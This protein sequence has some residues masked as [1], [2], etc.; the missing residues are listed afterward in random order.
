MNIHN[1]SGLGNVIII[2]WSRAAKNNI[3]KNT[4]HKKG[5]QSQRLC[6]PSIKL[7][8]LTPIVLQEI[9]FKMHKKVTKRQ[10]NK[11]MK[12]Y[13]YTFKRKKKITL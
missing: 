13:V 4:N 10:R 8:A 3:K 11:A 12:K 7:T 9:W 1:K 6:N 2:Y 5:T